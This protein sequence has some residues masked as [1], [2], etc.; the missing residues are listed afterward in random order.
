MNFAEIKKTFKGKKILITGHTGFK[1]SYLTAFLDQFSCNILGISIDKKRNF[2]EIKYSK[3][4]KSK[5]FDMSNFKK[6]NKEI[7]NFKPEIIFHLAAQPIVF[8]AHKFPADTWNSNLYST[9][10]LFKSIEN[11]S[12]TKCIIVITSDKVYEN[13]NNKKMMKEKDFLSGSETYSMSKVSVE[14]FVKFFVKRNK[15]INVLTARAG[16]VIGGGDWGEKRLIPDI[17]RSTQKKNFLKI[18]NPY[19]TR[20][21]MHVL[22]CTSAYLLLAERLYKKKIKSSSNWNI[23]PN[24][25]KHISV[26]KILNEFKEKFP[27]KFKIKSSSFHEDRYL[28]LNTQ[29][30][31]KELNWKTKLNF[32]ETVSL[33][34]KWYFHYL[35][36]KENLTLKQIKEFID[37]NKI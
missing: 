15:N 1:G 7:K 21:W 20:P 27:L 4:V 25:K 29:K 26:K 6:L 31:K 18:R 2:S 23:G 17:I 12:S 22:D 28:A 24:A 5:I 36:K 11:I 33:T 13:L 10:N 16:N 3:K 14:N 34:I 30:I 35:Y 8:N 19:S 9:L 37:E 32:T